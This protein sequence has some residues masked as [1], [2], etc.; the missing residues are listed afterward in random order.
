MSSASTDTS[1]SNLLHILRHSQ[2]AT[3]LYTS[4]E[5][6]VGFI[7]DA[8]L[9]ILNKSEIV[10]GQRLEDFAPEFGPYF[11]ILKTLWKTGDKLILKE[12]PADIDFDGNLVTN[13][14]DIEYYPVKDDS[15]RTTA[16][17]CTARNVN[18]RVFAEQA[19]TKKEEKELELI[20]ALENTNNALVD[21]QN[22]LRKINSELQNKLDQLSRNEQF[23][24]RVIMEAPAGLAL[25]RGP[26]YIY[27]IH[28]ATY[29]A[30]L[31]GR[32]LT[33]RGFF[34][35][36]AELKG[37]PLEEVL[38][39]V[40]HK[41]IPHSFS[42][43]L[44]ALAD[45]EGGPTVDR[46]FTFNYLPWVDDNGKVDGI[47]NMAVEVTEAV[48]AK[49]VISNLNDALQTANK[50][51]ETATTAA[52]IGTWQIEP[53]S[54]ELKYNEVLAKIFGYEGPEPM[55]YEQAIG[56]VLPDYKDKLV[57][58][59]NIAIDNG[60]YYNELYQQKRFNDG[61]VIWLRSTGQVSKDALSGELSFSGVVQD[62]TLQQEEEQRKNSFIGMV[63]HELKTPL[64]SLNSIVQVA[65]MKL[66]KS[67]DPWL[68]G[69]MDKATSQTKKMARLIDGFL[70]ISRLESGQLQ[71]VKQ[72]FIIGDLLRESIEEAKLTDLTY[73]IQ[74]NISDKV[75]VQ[76]DKDKIGSVITNFLGNAIK[77]SPKGTAIIVNCI[78][79]QDEVLV[80]IEDNGIGI[81]SEDIEKLFD[82]YYRV[83]D[84]A[85]KTVSGFGI[86]LYLSA[87]IIKH[88]G[89]KIGVE[90]VP[91]LG[92][93]FY[94]AIPV[95]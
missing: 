52:R 79:Q 45:Y 44:V 27:T 89:G 46:Y 40:Y 47:L 31:P 64:T 6:H 41:G 66:K 5:L 28:N 7:N 68:A 83:Q 65:A 43:S 72:P 38:H 13:Y 11:A 95:A 8:M 91:G 29:Q 21:M 61:K 14:F 39:D 82:R 42:E 53:L 16:I 20:K 32:N 10:E 60:G 87:E 88:H 2:D 50:Q 84:T 1:V 94:F 17:I 93:K 73:N 25:M 15:G 22:R 3:L 34:D 90:S 78:L 75:V 69:A 49:Q 55:T 51:L 74:L 35:A 48:K 26:S 92:S 56:Q 37:T 86:G 58:Q 12:S 30:I 81:R 67:E 71:I 62:V 85:A 23:L 18:E 77:Y 57:K 9:R 36:V 70:N 24:N 33:G 59:I 80:T 4:E 76:A 54:K 19:L 63:S